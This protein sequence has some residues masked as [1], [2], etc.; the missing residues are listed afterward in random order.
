MHFQ[1]LVGVLNQ[2]EPAMK[3]A[4]ADAKLAHIHEPCR[5][6]VNFFSAVAQLPGWLHVQEYI[7]NPQN[8]MAKHTMQPPRGPGGEPVRLGGAS[9][10]ST[11]DELIERGRLL[12]MSLCQ[13]IDWAV[14]LWVQYD[15]TAAAETGQAAVRLAEN[16]V[17]GQPY[18][19]VPS[20]VM[21]TFVRVLAADKQWSFDAT[22]FMKDAELTVTNMLTS[23]P[24][25]PFPRPA[26]L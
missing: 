14:R 5:V 7:V 2:L 20:R 12:M 21:D 15:A 4:S 9:T 1:V 24:V 16:K 26:C 6:L 10:P 19:A 25:T 17:I 11:I 3:A 18:T 23:N 13:R 22:H 8:Y